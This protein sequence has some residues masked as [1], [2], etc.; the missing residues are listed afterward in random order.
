MA[1]RSYA[2]RRA[3]T[4]WRTPHQQRGGTQQPP[5]QEPEWPSVMV[6]EP[7]PGEGVPGQQEGSRRFLGRSGYERQG[8]LPDPNLRKLPIRILANKPFSLLSRPTEPLFWRGWQRKKVLTEAGKCLSPSESYSTIPVKRDTG[9]WLV[10][11]TL[12]HWSSLTQFPWSLLALQSENRTSDLSD[13]WKKVL[14]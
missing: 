9:L 1:Q 6:P 12:L 8:S 14:D 7:G 3:C 13:T 2:S 11:Q 5:R 10:F 4:G